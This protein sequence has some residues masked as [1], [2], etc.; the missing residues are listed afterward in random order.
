MADWKLQYPSTSV[1][2]TQKGD[3]QYASL[4]RGEGDNLLYQLKNNMRFQELGQLK[5]TR[6]FSDGTKITAWSHFGLDHVEIDVSKTTLAVISCSITLIDI[7]DI[8][9][10]MR[11]PGEIHAGE[12][13]GTDYIKTYYE[14]SVE[15]PTCTEIEFEIEFIYNGESTC[16]YSED[17]GCWGEEISRGSDEGGTYFIWKVYTETDADS[18]SGL[19]YPII[20]AHIDTEDNKPLCEANES[21]TVDC[22]AKDAE[23]RTLT[24]YWKGYVQV[25]DTIGLWE[26]FNAG[27]PYAPVYFYVLPSTDGACLPI[28]WQT[29]G[30][31]TWVAGDE[32]QTTML[33]F[34]PED[35]FS[36]AVCTD[37]VATATD[38]C[39]TSDTFTADCCT[40]HELGVLYIAYT[41]LNMAVDQQQTLTAAGGC[42]PYEWTLVSGGGSIETSGAFNQSCLYTAP[43]TN[44]ECV[45]NPTVTVT[46]CCGDSA[47]IRMAINAYTINSIA[48]RWCGQE[49]LTCEC[50]Q[51]SGGDCILYS[52]TANFEAINWNCAGALYDETYTTTPYAITC[53]PVQGQCADGSGMG[54]C[55]L[56]LNCQCMPCVPSIG[57]LSQPCNT[58][59]DMRNALH[60]AGGCCPINPATGLPY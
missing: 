60:I 32:M 8:V 35:V 16:T 30:P 42:P 38:R 22:C 13:E 27:V 58:Y 1:S 6:H 48:Y 4:F 49:V 41:S 33:Y 37:V 20:R 18:R 24:I 43:S 10:P 52:F 47:T 55:M 2:R 50:I 25:P 19:G 54:N 51:W 5:M 39:G 46:D 59:K 53:N 11:Y 44:P 21:L 45:Y 17:N 15:C 26:L 12:V 40:T 57:C 36:N 7:P 34:R 9:Q 28:T 23:D 14:M 56:L 3:P 29:S 31:G